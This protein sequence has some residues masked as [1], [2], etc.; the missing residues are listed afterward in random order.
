MARWVE[1]QYNIKMSIVGWISR[2]KKNCVEMLFAQQNSRDELITNTYLT[3]L[4]GLLVFYSSF[5]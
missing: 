1:H 4:E 3:E 5:Y 2:L